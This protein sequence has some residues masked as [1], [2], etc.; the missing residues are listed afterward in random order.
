MN[1]ISELFFY[2]GI[3]FEI[4][5]EMQNS[6]AYRSIRSSLCYFGDEIGQLSFKEA[7]LTLMKS[8]FIWRVDLSLETDNNFLNFI[9][10]L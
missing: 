4:L 3:I 7:R 10:L 8:I 2:R 5:L 9:C 6:I 1:N